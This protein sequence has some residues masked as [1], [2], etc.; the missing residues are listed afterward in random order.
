MKKI[1][2]KGLLIL[3]A[4]LAAFPWLAKVVPGLGSYPE[5][6]IYAGIYSLITMGLSVLVGFAGQISLGHAAFFGIG[7]YASAVGT[8]TYNLDPWLC[9]ILGALLSLLVALAIG[10]PTLKLKGHYLAMATLAFGII[11]FIIFNE[12]VDITGGPDGLSR[13]P[14]LSLFGL[15]LNTTMSYFYFVWTV[16]LLVFWFCANLLE[17]RIGRAFRAVHGSEVAAMAMGINIS[18]HKVQAFV[19][20]AVLASLAG[21][22]YVHYINFINPSTCNL[23][24]SVK[25][26]IMI[27]MGGT[28]SL[29]GAILGAVL[30]TFLSNVWLH[31]FQEW[32]VLIYGAV[33][34]II[35]IFL[36]D[37]LAGLPEKIKGWAGR[38]QPGKAS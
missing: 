29:W 19:L 7:A 38:G 4:G 37:G 3:A 32:E 27:V 10:V 23:F 1:S 11:V 22:L 17:S 14:G 26:I 6:M 28:H 25:L 35:V 18:S 5:V 30:I 24:F 15:K 2:R 16:V 12:E 33:L 8:A 13:I 36:P 9:L 31:A 20:S 21:S 34:L